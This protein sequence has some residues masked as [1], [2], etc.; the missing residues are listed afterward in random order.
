MRILVAIANHGT[1]NRRFLDR[2]LAEYRSMPYDVDVVVL[3]DAPKDDL[4][5][6]VEVRVGAPTEDPWSL[7]FAHR[8][9]FAER[10]GDYDLYV[11]SEDDTLVQ[12]RHVKAFVEA[13]ALLAA[14]EVPGF[15][16]YEEYPDG[17][18]SYCSVHSAYHWDPASVRRADGEVF[19]RFTNQHSACY[20]LTREQLGRA[21]DSG[22]FLVDAHEGLYDMLVSAATD[23]YVRCGLRRVL[24]V[25][26]I[27]D[28]LLHHL[29]NV[30]LGK[31]GIS[32]A[33]WN[34]QIE[35]LHA[36]AGGAAS[37]GRLFETESRMDTA[38]WN[39]HY[40][41]QPASELVALLMR[42]ASTVLSIGCG[43]GVLEQALFRRARRI[44]GVPLD[45]VIAAVARG[46]GIETVPPDFDV[47]FEA[48]GGETFEVVL[49]HDVLGHVRDPAALLARLRPLVA[50]GGEVLASV[51]NHRYHA[52]RHRTRRRFSAP[53]P[54][55]GAFDEFGVHRTGRG[56]LGRWFGEAGY[57]VRRRHYR[58]G[59]RAAAVV[60]RV[61]I[62]RG[63]LGR[64][65]VVS[66]S[67]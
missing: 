21:I 58:H 37:A 23:P 53:V 61:P 44:V 45:E 11:Y 18:R 35:A 55:A 34:A 20:I 40:H 17:Q 14:D 26:R 22:G 29:P 30:Y 56:T 3:S 32:E 27:E 31:L 15:L 24:C 10:A 62:L 43:D 7:P 49:L 54:R 59:S 46:R 50:P 64:T 28:F 38:A 9:L 33:D 48:L 2:L 65:V 1:K 42:P 47:A 19:A 66:A 16:R 41:P 57:E 12:A 13:N 4:G 5:E 52:L 51:P 36:V 8:A 63:A 25:S 60:R 39:R 67:P 6:R